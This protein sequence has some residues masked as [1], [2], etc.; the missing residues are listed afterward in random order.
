MYLP[1][2]Y[3]FKIH[4]M[5][6]VVRSVVEKGNKFYPQISLNNSSYEV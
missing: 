5:A 1:V 4:S 2:E 6:I 3:V